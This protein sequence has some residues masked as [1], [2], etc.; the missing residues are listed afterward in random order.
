MKRW[1]G[2]KRTF[3]VKSSTASV[4]HSSVMYECVRMTKRMRG[5]HRFVT[6]SLFNLLRS[7]HKAL[8]V[9]QQSKVTRLKL[10]LRGLEGREQLLHHTRQTQ[11]LQM[12]EAE[13]SE[14][15]I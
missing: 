11:H 5:N 14:G 15:V 12:K 2:Y 8:P 4:N 3:T 7:H 1:N 9:M 6:K 13:G 10:L